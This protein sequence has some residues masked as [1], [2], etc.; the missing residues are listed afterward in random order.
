MV[1]A[2]CSVSAVNRMT[3]KA[4]SNS[5]SRDVAHAVLCVIAALQ[6]HQVDMCMNNS[7]GVVRL[8]RQTTAKLARTQA[9]TG[10]C[11]YTSAAAGMLMTAC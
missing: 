2:P 4:H 5:S 8:V 6:L 11:V 1:P 10:T 7:N 9:C 3:C